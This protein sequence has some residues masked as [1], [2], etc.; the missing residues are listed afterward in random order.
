MPLGEQRGC[1]VVHAGAGGDVLPAKAWIGVDLRHLAPEG[2]VAVVGSDDRTVEGGNVA[3][4]YV[5]D[6]PRGAVYGKERYRVLPRFQG[7]SVRNL[8]QV[9]RFLRWRTGCVGRLRGRRIG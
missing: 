7:G 6:G 5:D 4:G 2:H 1:E 3:L 8:C 9:G